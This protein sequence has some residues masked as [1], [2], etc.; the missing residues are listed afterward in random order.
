LLAAL[1]AGDIDPIVAHTITAEEAAG[2][3]SASIPSDM[4]AQSALPG[5]YYT[6]VLQ[7]LS[8]EFHSAPALL[9]RLNPRRAI[10]RRRGNP[11]TQPVR[12]GA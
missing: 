12:S 7:E 10:Y 11:R 8:Q 2:P 5:L 1:G 9:E 4:L 3:F 6:S